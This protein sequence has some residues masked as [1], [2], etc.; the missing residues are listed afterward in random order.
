MNTY[1]LYVHTLQRSS[2]LKRRTTHY[3][4]YYA[5]GNAQHHQ[6][7][8]LHLFITATHVQ[9]YMTVCASL[10]QIGLPLSVQSVQIIRS[11]F[12]SHGRLGIAKH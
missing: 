7:H 4:L 9:T 8:V 3:N 11:E 12:L 2:W 1:C 6:W 5:T 10:E